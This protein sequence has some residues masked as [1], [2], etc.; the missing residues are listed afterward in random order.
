MS[1]DPSLNAMVY[2]ESVARTGRVAK[3]AEQLGVSPSA[4]SQ[5]I[6]HLENLLGVAL[7]RRD[8]R[9]LSLT[10]EGEQMFTAASSAFTTLDAARRR[11]TR[12][13]ERQQLIARV[14]PSFG[15][16]WLGQR[17]VGFIDAHPDWD[18]RI[19]ATADPTNF[20]R[21]VVDLDLRYGHGQWP[22]LVNQCVIQDS[23]FPMCSPDYL[24]RT[25]VDEARYIDSTQAAIQWDR[26]WAEQSMTPTGDYGALRFER[27][28]M[29]IQ[30]AVNGV[31]VVLESATLA[32]DELSDARLVPWAP[33]QGALR[34]PAY[35]AVCPPGHANRRLLRAFIDWVQAEGTAHESAIQ[36]Y[37][38]AHAIRI[39]QP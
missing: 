18:L 32:W 14:S 38:L 20:D 34:F 17:L 27:S 16:R 4:V 31:G 6:K 11:I 30:Q 19:D 29:A 37:L 26:W 25:A 28:S 2:F 24:A 5:Q 23:V 36:A 9:E 3:A 1:R 35:W 12:Q 7:F 13:R 22:G 15:V 21:E 39:Q 10:L 33:E 8:K